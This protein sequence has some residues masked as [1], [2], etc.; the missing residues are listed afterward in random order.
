[1]VT[2]FDPYGASTINR[3]MSYNSVKIKCKYSTFFVITFFFRTYLEHIP[4]AESLSKNI[5]TLLI[6]F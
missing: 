4:Q 6:C 5:F 2:K 1:M 3:G